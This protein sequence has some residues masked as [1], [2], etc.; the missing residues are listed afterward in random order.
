MALLVGS[1]LCSVLT[2]LYVCGLVGRPLWS[3]LDA[4]FALSVHRAQA[5]IF[6][7]RA[8]SRRYIR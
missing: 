1:V 5:V 2:E 4:L 3:G 8:Q 7:F 6:H